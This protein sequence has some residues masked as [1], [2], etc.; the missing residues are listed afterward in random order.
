MVF[1]PYTP[2]VHRMPPDP[3]S[4]RPIPVSA[5]S[6]WCSSLVA[7][8]LVAAALFRRRHTICIALI[9]YFKVVLEKE[10]A[11]LEEERR[12][13]EEAV[14]RLAR[15]RSCAQLLGKHPGLG[16]RERVGSVPISVTHCSHA[17]SSHMPTRIPPF[18]TG[19]GRTKWCLHR[20]PSRGRALQWMRS[21]GRES[22]HGELSARISR[23]AVVL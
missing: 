4:L 3:S 6:R 14:V 7:T 15:P 18:R 19:N 10:R 11:K 12:L 21:R 13:W 16:V 23:N 20:F 17:R 22:V 5:P 9:S 1:V 8:P 2:A